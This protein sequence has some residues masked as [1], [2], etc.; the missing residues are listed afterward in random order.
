MNHTITKYL[1]VAL[2]ISL[3]GCGYY[4]IPLKTTPAKLGA[5]T[6]TY[7]ELTAM[8]MPKEKVVATVYKFRDQ[9]GQ[10]KAS[11]NGT[12]WSTAVT[13]GGTSI[14]L[15][16]LEDSGWFVPIERE[17]LSDLLNERKII[18]SSRENFAQESGKKMENLPPLLY[19]GIILE[20]G[21]ISYETNIMTGGMGVKYFGTGAS[22]EYRQDQVTIYLRAIST[23]TGRILKTVYTTKTILSQMVDVG[24]F[25]FVKVSRLLEAETGYSANEPVVMCVTEA[26]EKA[27]LSLII[28][29]IKDNLWQLNNPADINS[30]IIEEYN[31]EKADNTATNYANES[32]TEGTK[33]VGLSFNFS[34]QI[35]SGDYSNSLITGGVNASISNTFS[36]DFS[37]QLNAGAGT[38]RAGKYFD[39]KITYIGLAA[40]E[41][42]V[43][44]SKFSPYLILGVGATY[45]SSLV[46]NSV[47]NYN[48]KI[49]WFFSINSGLG[50]EFKLL[51]NFYF[52]TA[53]INHYFFT[54]KLDGVDQGN[55]Y[56]YYWTGQMG[57]TYYI[58]F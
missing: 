1:L 16:A 34:P 44:D 10:Y 27:V 7:K 32:T 14:L 24:L 15:K 19:A 3:T 53:V 54:D 37:I 11:D 17:G 51:N 30:K 58:Q 22:G 38:L 20:G 6:V 23:Q 26:I 29:G 13:Q 39:S 28:E 52:N 2:I 5:P 18:R 57:F 31:K 41:N 4:D 47:Q 49:G 12:T 35:Y 8:P 56:D 43:P 48:N 9:S 21:I 36:K 55:L 46:V 50:F 40:K 42:F 45:R 25:K 33:G